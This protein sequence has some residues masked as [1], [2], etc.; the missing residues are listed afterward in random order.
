MAAN[1]VKKTDEVINEDDVN[2]ILNY[3][4]YGNLKPEPS[5]TTRRS[6]RRDT[7]D[8][9]NNEPIVFSISDIN[10]VSGSEVTATLSVT[11]LSGLSSMGLTIAYNT[12]VIS[13]IVK[14]SKTGIASSAFVVYN[15][16]DGAGL[17]RIS[18]YSKYDSSLEGSGDIATITLRLTEGGTL[19]STSLFIAQATL[20]D[21]TN[22]RSKQVLTRFLIKVEKKL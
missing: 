15:A 22:S 9:E 8:G 6:I 21:N 12:D 10:S 19:R 20:Y 11:N 2:A 16:Y 17:G 5:T 7:R 4:F 14:V 1:V 3:A 13:E 18:V